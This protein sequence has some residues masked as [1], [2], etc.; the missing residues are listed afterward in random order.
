MKNVSL[1]LLLGTLLLLSSCVIH[2]DHLLTRQE[3]M[4]GDST[5]RIVSLTMT[6]GNHVEFANSGGTYSPSARQITGISKNGKSMSIPLE[7]LGM[8]EVS[9]G[10]FWWSL[11]FWYGAAALFVGILFLTLP[12]GDWGH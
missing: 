12:S 2:S 3:L 10:S 8:A 9:S 5:D 1:F 6:D 11:L 7:S 4:F